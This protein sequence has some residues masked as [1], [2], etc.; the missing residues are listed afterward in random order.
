MPGLTAAAETAGASSEPA[1]ALD[2]A[3]NRT[4]SGER[5]L[6]HEGHMDE[7]QGWP[8]VVRL[9]A[10][11]SVTLKFGC[12]WTP[13]AASASHKSPW[14]SVEPCPTLGLHLGKDFLRAVAQQVDFGTG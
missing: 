4:V 9:E 5:W 12:Q 6:R 8:E 1:G 7:R 10:S 11:C 14:V 2:S 3:C 13:G